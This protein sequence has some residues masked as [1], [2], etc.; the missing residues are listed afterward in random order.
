MK[1]LYIFTKKQKITICYS[2]QH[3]LN[4]INKVD[5]K[6]FLL[7]LKRIVQSMQTSSDE[8]KPFNDEEEEKLL[9]TLSVDQPE[10]NLL[11]D[12]SILI[13]TQV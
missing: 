1:C 6:K 11:L 10:L 5:S 9:V 2:L 12:S 4:V 8:M 3:G 7:I 13:I